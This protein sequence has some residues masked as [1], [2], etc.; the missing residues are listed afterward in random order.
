MLRSKTV[1][2]ALLAMCAA[3]TTSTAFGQR[4]RQALRPAQPSTRTVQEQNFQRPDRDADFAAMIA[5]ENEGE[6]KLAQFALKHAQSDDVKKFA[7][8]MIDQHTQLVNKLDQFTAHRE[9]RAMSRNANEPVQNAAPAEAQNN[10]NPQTN[11]NAPTNTQTAVAPNPVGHHEMLGL[12]HEIGERC[13]QLTEQ[14]LSQKRGADFDRCYVGSQ[15]SAHIHA[16]A[17]ME[18]VRDHAQG[19]LR[20]VLDDG[21]HAAQQHLAMA[22]DLAKKLESSNRSSQ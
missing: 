13:L 6:V 12:H 9:H 18:V 1:F 17:A 14:E 10:A 22:K 5:G 16:I 15:I 3:L 19:N 8:T 21:V 20:Q 4:L 7:Q 2:L 11:A